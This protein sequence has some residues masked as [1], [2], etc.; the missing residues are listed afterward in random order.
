MHPQERFLNRFDPDGHGGFVYRA[1]PQSP[2]LSVTAEERVRM[3]A[4]DDDRRSIAVILYVLTVPLA[5]SVTVVLAM[6]PVNRPW[7][8][9]VTWSILLGLPMAAA[10][11]VSMAP[12]RILRG[13]PHVDRGLPRGEAERRSIREKSW[14]VLIVTALGGVAAGF[15][16]AS[17]TGSY[18]VLRALGA[19]CALCSIAIF[20]HEAEIKFRMRASDRRGRGN[21]L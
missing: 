1:T 9:A 18:M 17:W 8:P 11:W 2:G 7:A 20:A 3:I 19:F 16:M 5:V 14:F 4:A 6:D 21:E 12:N 15:N 13:H 10:T